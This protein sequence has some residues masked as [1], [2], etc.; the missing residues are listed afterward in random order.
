MT[1]CAYGKSGSGFLVTF[2]NSTPC[3]ADFD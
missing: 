2:G 3:F 1:T